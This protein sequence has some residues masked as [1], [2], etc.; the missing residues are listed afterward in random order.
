MPQVEAGG[1]DKRHHLQEAEAIVGTQAEALPA[2][3][4]KGS[5]Q[6]VQEGLQQLEQATDHKREKVEGEVLH[7]LGGILLL[8]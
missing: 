4:E 6:D 5:I 3:G 2:A 1:G 8:L 7:G